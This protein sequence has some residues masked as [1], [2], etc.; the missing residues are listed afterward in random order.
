MVR[1]LI[2]FVAVSIAVVVQLTIVDPATVDALRAQL[3]FLERVVI[4]TRTQAF[5]QTLGGGRAASNVFEYSITACKGCLIEYDT[6][7]T[8][9]PVPNCFA[10]PPTSETGPTVCFVG[11][12]SPVDCHVC[13]IQDPFCLCG[14]SSCH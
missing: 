2:S 12:D 6:D 11:Q 3:S 5:G 9:T 8:Q 4:V 14:Q 1:G 10:A 13:S 7:P